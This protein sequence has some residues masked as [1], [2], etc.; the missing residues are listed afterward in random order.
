VEFKLFYTSDTQMPLKRMTRVMQNFMVNCKGAEAD[1][2]FHGGDICNTYPGATDKIFLNSFLNVLGA[3]MKHTPV[4]AVSRGNHEY[5]GDYSGDFFR[6]FGG[7]EN[8]SYN[9]FRQGNVCFIVL[10][11][12]EDKPR[13]PKTENYGRTFDRVLMNEQRAWLEQVVKTPEFQTAKF[14]IVLLHSPMTEKY[15]G[16][17]GKILTDGLLTGENAPHKIH[18]WVTAHTHRYARTVAAGQT[19][20][21]VTDE[22]AAPYVKSPF[23]GKSLLIVNDGPGGADLNIS[24]LLFH[25][26]ENEINIKAMTPEGDVFDHFSVFPDGSLKE[27]DT[28]L[29]LMKLQ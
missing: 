29:K 26:K 8:K 28:K 7:R 24:G 9:M 15:M 14:R 25:F 17:S 21:R 23:A 22:K 12:G 19:A 5:R 20:V 4:V 10:D 27:H 11:A 1:I 18:L 2:F 13:I 3:E 16:K 6:Y